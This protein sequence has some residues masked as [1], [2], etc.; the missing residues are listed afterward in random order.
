LPELSAAAEPDPEAAAAD[1]LL[2]L[3]V[4]LLLEHPP[5][6]T[7]AAAATA[8]APVTLDFICIPTLPC[9]RFENIS[10]RRS[11]ID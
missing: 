2:E 6:T 1:V 3:A 5:R 7:M 11:S 4:S 10:K 9:V 8:M